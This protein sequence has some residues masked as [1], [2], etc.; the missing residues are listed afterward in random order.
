M[1]KDKV[2]GM[3]LGV[4]IGDQLGM[5]VE[6]YS[7]AKIRERHGRIADYIN[8]DPDH[9][10]FGGIK[11][12]WTDDTQLTLAVAE[13]LIEKKCIDWDHL[14]MMHVSA[15]RLGGDLGW[16]K[17]T[18][19]AVKKLAAGVHWL[20]SGSYPGSGNGVVMKIAPFALA[21]SSYLQASVMRIVPN[22]VRMTHRS[23]DAL[24]S[25]AAHIGA[26]ESC[27]NQRTGT[28]SRMK[29]VLE[30]LAGRKEFSWII[31]GLA[32]RL[33]AFLEL[34]LEKLAIEEKLML[35]G[36]ANSLV[37]NSLPFCYSMFLENPTSIYALYDTV[38]AGGDTDTNGSIVGALLGALNG[39]KVFSKHLID[40]LWQKEKIMDTANR[41]CETFGIPD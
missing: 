40:G 38:N 22:F 34:A 27:L 26:I 9:K 36:G 10:W 4:A 25:A 20:V 16:G 7:Y 30:M 41:L 24:M 35:F 18:K 21:I 14:A 3:M 1:T 6:T 15:L 37:Y 13:S 39:T 12:R 11:S 29:F 28:F 19:Q 33:N 31:D 17:S 32:L 8:P 5:P 2:R 23:N